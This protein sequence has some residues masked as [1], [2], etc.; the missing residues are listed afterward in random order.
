[1]SPR[2]GSS[3]LGL[4]ELMQAVDKEKDPERHDKLMEL[5]DQTIE[6]MK[7]QRGLQ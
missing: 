1:M 3:R 4:T 7:R 5:V 6:D 2:K